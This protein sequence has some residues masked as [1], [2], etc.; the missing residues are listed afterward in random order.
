SMLQAGPSS[1]QPGTINPLTAGQ[2]QPQGVW[3][4][5]AKVVA[6]EAAKAV[7]SMLQAG[8]SSQQPG[9]ISPLTADQLQP[10]G[11]WNNNENIR[12]AGNVL[13]PSLST[14]LRDVPNS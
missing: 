9:T 12:N 8:P 2:L 1:Q 6:T 3:N 13:I 5:V 11:I 14:L 10:Q 4:D 7:I